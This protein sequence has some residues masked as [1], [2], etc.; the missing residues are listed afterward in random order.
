MSQDYRKMW[1]NLGLNLAAHDALLEVLG[2]GYK[3]IFMTQENRPKGMSYFD[4][5]ISEVH[6]LRVKELLDEKAAGRKVIGS[7]C[8]FVPEEIVRAADAT[9]VGLCTGAD[10][11]TEEVEK[12]LPRNTCALIKSA[13][14]F[15]LGKVCPYIESADMIVGEN[16]CDGKKKS[17][18]TLNGLVK[19]L[20]VM[21][22]PQTKSPQGRALLKTEYVR[23]KEKVEN[24]TGV[25][26]DAARLRKGIDIVNN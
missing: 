5:V 23:F 26:I 6:G 11:A 1:G 14:G 24:L 25:K 15:K 7:F 22:L 2:K 8:V 9:L 3:D 4:F 19:Y 12:L 16:T 18:E 13:F 17:Y 10:F 20:Y 21:D